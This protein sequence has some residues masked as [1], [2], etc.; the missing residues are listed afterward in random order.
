M[1]ARE[2][3]GKH[4]SDWLGSHEND[5][6]CEAPKLMQ[7]RLMNN[8]ICFT[9]EILANIVAEMKNIALGDEVER[10]HCAMCGMAMLM[11]MWLHRDQR[12]LIVAVVDLARALADG[13]IEHAVA[14]ISGNEHVSQNLGKLML[15]WK[16]G[17][18]VEEKIFLLVS[19]LSEHVGEHRK[20]GDGFAIADFDEFMPQI[21]SRDSASKVMKEAGI[22]TLENMKKCERLRSA[23]KIA[24][25]KLTT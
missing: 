11:S 6:G 8:G 9:E 25:K 2:D 16:D 19:S 7:K 3:C 14:A 23:S 18:E 17:A 10:R 13:G 12:G 1:S 22:K 5:C 15:R 20:V 24:M 21:M 4:F